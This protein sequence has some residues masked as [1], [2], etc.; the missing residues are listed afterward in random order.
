MS[1]DGVGS[2]WAGVRLLVISVVGV[3]ETRGR[4]AEVGGF[5]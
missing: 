4:A 2:V 1:I 5:S 3:W